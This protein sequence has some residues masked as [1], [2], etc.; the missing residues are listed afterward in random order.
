M[1][2]QSPTTS[3]IGKISPVVRTVTDHFGAIADYSG[4]VASEFSYRKDE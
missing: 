4:I 1:L 3:V 2:T